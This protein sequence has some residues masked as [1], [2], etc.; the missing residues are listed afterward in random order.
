MTAGYLI[1]LPIDATFKL[2]KAGVL[3]YSFDAKAFEAISAHS[4]L[5]VPKSPLEHA[6]LIKFHNPW[7]IRTQPGY[8][9]LCVSPF[10]RFQIPF[11]NMTAIVETDS[12]YREVH[13]PSM[14]V[15]E[16]G[17]TLKLPRGI[18]IAQVIPFKCEDFRSAVAAVD[19]KKLNDGHKEKSANRHIYKEQFWRRHDFA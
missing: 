16:P 18:P 1:P 9:T 8:S 15:M 14:C 10:N 11:I 17:T 6:A 19:E 2:D 3:T 7:V 12:Y 13:F 4:P 5:Q